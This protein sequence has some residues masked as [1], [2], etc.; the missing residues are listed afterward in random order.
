M[1]LLDTNLCIEVLR[2]HPTAIKKKLQ[3][4]KHVGIS[5]IVYSELCY[6][7]AMSPEHTQANR[8]SQLDQ[9]LTFL[10]IYPWDEQAAEHYATIRGYLQKRGTL[11]GNMDLLIAAHARSMDATLVTNN[12]REFSRV[13]NLTLE[14]WSSTKKR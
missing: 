9:F 12:R 6:G 2:H 11:I 4:A 14:D 7:I 13:P 1:Y 3:A 5:V 10:E 8:Q